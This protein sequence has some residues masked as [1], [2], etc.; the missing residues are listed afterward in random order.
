MRVLIW[1][2]GISTLFTRTTNLICFSLSFFRGCEGDFEKGAATT[3]Q[4]WIKKRRQGWTTT[5]A[6]PFVVHHLF[7]NTSTLHKALP[8]DFPSLRATI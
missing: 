4:E 8:V 6:L 7:C 2:A 5:A 3:L 1:L